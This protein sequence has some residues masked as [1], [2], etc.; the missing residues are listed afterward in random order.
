[1]LLSIN[2]CS[3]P[4]VLVFKT[5]N[6]TTYIEFWFVDTFSFETLIELLVIQ[7]LVFPSFTSWFLQSCVWLKA[8]PGKESR[9][10]IN[11]SL[12]FYEVP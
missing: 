4:S 11:Q 6:Q 9:T 5:T 1:M 3:L 7:N 2:V 10:P 12:F 8:E